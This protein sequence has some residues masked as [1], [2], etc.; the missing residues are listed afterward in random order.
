MG[1][2]RYL[3]RRFLSR[4]YRLSRAVRL[5]ALTWLYRRLGRAY[6]TLYLAAELHLSLVIAVLAILFLT[7]YVPMDWDTELLP[8]MGVALIAT[9]LASPI[10]VVRG[11]RLL[12]PVRE[13]IAGDRGAQQQRR[14]RG[15]LP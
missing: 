15:A 8:F 3:L 13:W 12:K 14:R 11:H 6:P 9:E 4:M 1:M 2:P 5:Q 7:L 10:S